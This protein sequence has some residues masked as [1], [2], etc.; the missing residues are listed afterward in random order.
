VPHARLG[1]AFAVLSVGLN[2]GIAAA[3]LGAGLLND[4][5]GAGPANPAGYRPMMMLFAACGAAGF[6]FALRLRK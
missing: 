6:A 4:A 5:F 3:N 1:T 2:V